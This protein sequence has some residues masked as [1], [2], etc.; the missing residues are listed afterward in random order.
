MTDDPLTDLIAAV[1]AIAH[2]PTSGPTG[3]ELVAMALAGRGGSVAESLDRIANA[4]ERLAEV[5]DDR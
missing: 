5:I 2:G 1:R 3:L 4:I